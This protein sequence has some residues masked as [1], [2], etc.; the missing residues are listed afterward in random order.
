MQARGLLR[1]PP[2]EKAGGPR[3]LLA[4]AFISERD[5]GLRPLTI[6][7]ERVPGSRPLSRPLTSAG[8]FYLP[9][10][11]NVSCRSL[12]TGACFEALS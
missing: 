7:T 1:I 12:R 11:G 8:G 9:P 4:A 3:R 5:V 6:G 2:D 10:C